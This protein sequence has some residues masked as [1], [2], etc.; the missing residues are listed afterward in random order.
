MTFDEQAYIALCRKQIEHKFAFGNGTGYT[1]RDL[2]FLAQHIEEKTGITLS[3]STM[4][5]L[6]KG[7]F[8]QSPQIATLNALAAVLDYKDWQEFKLQN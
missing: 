2:E 3:L 5:R 4:K 7:N 6:W 8:K 1:Q